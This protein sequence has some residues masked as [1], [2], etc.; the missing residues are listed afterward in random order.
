M[1]LMRKLINGSVTTLVVLYLSTN[2]GTDGC[3]IRSQELSTTGSFII[4]VIRFLT[5][6]CFQLN[7]MGKEIFLNLKPVGFLVCYFSQT[8]KVEPRMENK[9]EDSERIIALIWKP[10]L[11]IR[12]A[13]VQIKPMK[14]HGSAKVARGRWWKRGD[15]ALWPRCSGGFCFCGTFQNKLFQSK[16]SGNG[17][18]SPG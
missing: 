8:G 12:K 18:E 10:S 3:T 13:E 7:Y 4:I 2:E 14:S 16:R 9:T 1:K 5:L 6:A 15:R 11:E 17:E